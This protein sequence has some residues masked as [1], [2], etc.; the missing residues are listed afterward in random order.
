[1][2]RVVVVLWRVGRVARVVSLI[3]SDGEPLRV[4]SG[5]AMVDLSIGEVRVHGV[6]IGPF[7]P[8]LNERTWNPILVTSTG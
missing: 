5:R 3:G 8:S 4:P 6:V 2:I 7:L 1:M